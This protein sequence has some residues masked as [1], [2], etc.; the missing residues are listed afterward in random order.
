VRVRTEV[1]AVTKLLDYRVPATWRDP[2]VVGTRVRM[3]LHGRSVTGWV[4]EDDVVPPAGLEV[5]SLK[6][7]LGWGPPPS[8]VA[9]AE[10]AAWRWA[11]PAS[12]FLRVGSSVP[13]V[14][15]LPVVA[16]LAPAS[17]QRTQA[18]KG[19]SVL[20][21]LVRQVPDDARPVATVLRIPPTTD[22]I[23]LIEVEADRV[24]SADSDAS[25]LVLVPSVG[26][27]ERLVER[28]RRRGY[29]ATGDWAEAR[30]GWPIVVGSRAAAWAPVPRLAAAI[31][32][33]AHDAA[34]REESAPTY[35]AVDVVIERARREASRCLLVSPVPTAGISV[36]R[37]EL[38][39]PTSVERAG[40]AAFEC[41]DR[42]GTDPRLGL[43][44]EEFVKLARE[45]LDD[46]EQL[47]RLGPLV[48]VY[49]RTGRARLLACVNCGEVARCTNCGA[50][51]AQVGELLHCPRCRAERPCV[52]AVC[53]RLKMK[54]LRAGVTRL[55]EEL[56]ALL[57]VE[58]TELAGPTPTRRSG[59]E[60]EALP[61]TPV[62]LG[63]KA[64]LHRLR[65]ASAVVFLDVD[66]H[67]LAPRLDATDE[68]LAL[69][70]R[71]A[72]LCGPRGAGPRT[73]R[74]M[75]QTRV[76]EHPVIAAALLGSPASVLSQEASMRRT[77]ALPPF[78]A[79]A[80]VS[81][82]QAAAYA[83]S[84]AER[85]DGTSVRLSELSADMYLLRAP[86]H[87]SLC[88]LLAQVPRPSGAGLRVEVDPVSV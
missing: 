45:V 72:R 37:T 2:V 88:D 38:A 19:D 20:G 52:C 21:E 5:L 78:S 42:R 9:L 61:A 58:V 18:E 30:A 24:S 66:L 39:L 73:R 83:T 74:I 86:D 31:V 40:W 22:L 50:A 70:V 87:G 65:R 54:T 10:W 53:G 27:A 4:V 69:M 41:V 36:G 28:L 57:S 1:A 26:W 17:G 59:L 6:S 49:D 34:Y 13:V 82:K 81:G 51:M 62:V 77:A 44:S 85:I 48:C 7:W 3:P 25:V 79:L 33:D 68:S 64:A 60:E 55:R 47:D 12:F 56:A 80:L 23:G 16:A 46:R 67:L 84:A 71:A 35:S 14:R 76:P 63:T 75:L 29:R 15:A 32:L 43:F 11:G 8:V